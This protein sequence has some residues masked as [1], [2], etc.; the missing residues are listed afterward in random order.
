MEH[1]KNRLRPILYS[2]LTLLCIGAVLLTLLVINGEI[3]YRQTWYLYWLKVLYQKVECLPS[4]G[5]ILILV[6]IAVLSVI[7]IPSN[8]AKISA[9]VL[10][11]FGCVFGCLAGLLSLYLIYHHIHSLEFN[12]EYYQIGLIRDANVFYPET[13]YVVCRCADSIGSVCECQIF[14][15]V[16]EPPTIC[17][18]EARLGIDESTGMVVVRVGE[19]IVYTYGEP[20]SYDCFW[21]SRCPEV[22][23]PSESSWFTGGAAQHRLHPTR[24]SPLEIGGY[25]RFVVGL[26]AGAHS[27]TRR[28]GEANR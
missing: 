16:R 13:D 1:N 3:L 6:G 19:R 9:C 12:G 21:N 22:R 4:I 27:R 20:R 8:A 23:P 24:L 17:A 26:V 28:A 5:L 18:F 2:L 7:A 14:C 25:T 11:Y 15:S 10:A